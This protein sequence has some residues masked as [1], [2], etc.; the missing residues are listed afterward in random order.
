MNELAVEWVGEKAW[1]YQTT[2]AAPSV[3]EGGKID[4]VFDGLDTFA[5]VRLNDSIILTSDN[6]FLKHRVNVNHLIR[7]SENSLEIEFDSALLRGRELEK[8]H[9]EHRFLCHNGETGRLA[10]RKAQYHWVCSSLKHCGTEH[11]SKKVDLGLGLGSGSH[12]C[13]PM[14]TSED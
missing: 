7:A 13:R 12:D 8:Q 9:P 11:S 2:F 4:L 5:T 6:M 3:P 14:E 1:V 10:V